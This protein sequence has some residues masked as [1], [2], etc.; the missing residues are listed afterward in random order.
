MKVKKNNREVTIIDQSEVVEETVKFYEDLYSNKDNN[1]KIDNIEDF[2]G[3]NISNTCPKLTEQ[4]KNGMEGLIT[5]DELT[6]YLKKCRNNVSPGSTGFTGSLALSHL[7]VFDR[8]SV[9]I[10]II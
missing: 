5:L 4:Q 1:I 9:A 10:T 8:S 6:K 2:L 7:K 3:E